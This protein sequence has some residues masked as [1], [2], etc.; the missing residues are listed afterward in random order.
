MNSQIL[1]RLL[2]VW[3][4]NSFSTTIEVKCDSFSCAYQCSK[5][6]VRAGYNM[7][8]C[9]QHQTGTWKSGKG[10]WYGKLFIQEFSNMI[11]SDSLIT[12]ALHSISKC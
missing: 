8:K 6:F 9:I 4:G 5:I 12:C 11:V 3:N 1:C 10:N 2:N 7:S